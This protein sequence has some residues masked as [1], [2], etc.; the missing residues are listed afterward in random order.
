M[1][2]VQ[3]K[4]FDD[5]VQRV[6]VFCTQ[7]GLVGKSRFD[8]ALD[9]Y[10]QL[11]EYQD[12]IAEHGL[13]LPPFVFWVD[14]LVGGLSVSDLLQ[15]REI[16]E[17]RPALSPAD[18]FSTDPSLEGMTLEKLP[19]D[20]D[21]KKHTGDLAL[22]LGWLKREEID[23]VAHLKALLKDRLGVRI[24]AAALLMA[25][26]RLDPV[27]YFQLM[28]FKLNIPFEKL[29]LESLDAVKLALSQIDP[30]SYDPSEIRFVPTGD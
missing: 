27:R 29:S 12:E 9:T 25:T 16:F 7:Q 30:S 11:A 6:R 23:G 20:L 2:D 21:Q 14:N 22:Q 15:M 5:A 13:P 17:G 10:I 24:K 8:Y 1:T 18:L 19:D 26:G 4:A 28:S 3:S